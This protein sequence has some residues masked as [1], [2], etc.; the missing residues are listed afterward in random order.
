MHDV[1]HGSGAGWHDA[2]LIARRP[3][4]YNALRH[5]NSVLL[6][7]ALGLLILLDFTSPVTAADPGPAH[8]PTGSRDVVVVDRT[9]NPDW[10]AATKWAVARWDEAGA[11]IRLTWQEAP[12]GDCSPQKVRIV[13]CTATWRALNTPFPIGLEAQVSP[14]TGGPHDLS[15]QI[16]VCSDCDMDAARREAVATHEVGHALGLVHDSRPESVMFPT[17]GAVRPDAGDVAALRAA[18]AHDDA[19][20]RCGLVHLHLGPLCA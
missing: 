19:P 9:G 12:A 15:S 4:V 20:T 16:Q 18:Y 14:D 5:A 13:V 6:G 2:D 10:Q 3:W 8:W 7:L 11:R 17:G 1:N